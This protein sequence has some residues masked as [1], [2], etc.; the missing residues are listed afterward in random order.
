MRQRVLASAVIHTDDTPVPVQEKG[1]GT[2]RQ[3]RFWVYVGDRD[4]RY[5]V[6][7]YT[8]D[9]SRAGPLRWL[10]G[11]E[12]YLQADAYAG[13]Q[14]LY[15][16]GRVT[17]VACWA[18]A[19]RKF[20]DARMTMPGVCFEA[21]AW[22]RRLYEIEREARDRQLDAQMRHAL[23]QERAVP[24]L[25][26]IRL[27]LHDQ[28]VLPKSPTGQAIEYVRSRWEAFVRYTSSGI[29]EIDN[30]AAENALR[31]VALGRKNWLFA[32]S[33]NGGDT[34]ATLFSLIASCALHDVD[35][36]AWLR[37]ALA[38]IAD[39][40]INQLEELLP[41]RWAANRTSRPAESEL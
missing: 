27:W 24:L 26:Q 38:R 9:R 41:D 22:I 7:D 10:R 35:P 12:G 4:H 2:T 29:L 8:A 36:Y 3:G 23:R 21:I 28:D 17:E 11:Y 30:N 20:H 6:F 13:Y 31:R 14:E 40:P 39:T 25:E 34:A 18:H 16:T 33:D 32:G 5:A 15:R 1:R 19:R 37:D